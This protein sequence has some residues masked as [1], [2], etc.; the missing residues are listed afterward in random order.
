MYANWFLV[1]LLVPQ[2]LSLKLR[3]S[4]NATKVLSYFSF[5]FDE[6]CHYIDIYFLSF[7]LAKTPTHFY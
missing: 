6:G 1:A 2:S 3:F 5:R 4:E 7:I